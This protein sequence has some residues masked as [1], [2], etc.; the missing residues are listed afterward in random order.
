[1]LYKLRFLY[2]ELFIEWCYNIVANGDKDVICIFLDDVQNKSIELHIA[3]DGACGAQVEHNLNHHIHVSDPM[4]LMQTV[5]H[6][7]SV[8]EDVSSG[9]VIIQLRPITDQA[10]QNLLDAKNNNCLIEMIFGMLLHINVANV[11]NTEENVVV[12][13]RVLYASADEAKPGYT[14]Y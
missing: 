6:G 2:G 13:V 11:M 1:M 14:I 3:V 9:S 5:S 12:K 7:Q 4:I 10:I 8:I